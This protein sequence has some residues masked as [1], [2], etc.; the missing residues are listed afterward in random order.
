[1]WFQDGAGTNLTSIMSEKSAIGLLLSGGLDSSILLGYLLRQNRRV[2][3][4][5]VRTGVVWEE[6]ELR[7]IECYMDALA[8]PLLENLVALDLPL[9]DIY[10]DHW[11]VTGHGTPDA[12]SEDRAVYLPSRNALLILKAAVWCQLHG[13]GQLALGVL[14]TNPFA[15][16]TEEFFRS[17]ESALN[18]D[19]SGRVR[20]ARP[21]A[22]LNKRQVMRLGR[23]LPLE[24][25]FSCISPVG[26]LHCGQCNKCSERLA[27]FRLVGRHD[28][29]RY[30]TAVP[31]AD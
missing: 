6:E 12:A 11:S 1:M 7:S 31:A 13:V 16:A 26:G 19:P 9:V 21:L 29:T 18:C 20:I 24:L 14:N 25:T 15:D 30:A 17:L 23:G 4:F 10:G 28:A 8:S 2:Q 22:G 3:P 5:Y 27:A